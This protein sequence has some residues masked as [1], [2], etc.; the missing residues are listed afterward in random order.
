VKFGTAVA[1]AEFR[2]PDTSVLDGLAL[3][4]DPR[5][6]Y[7]ASYLPTLVVDDEVEV[8]G[9][10][11]RVRSIKAIGDGSEIETTLAKV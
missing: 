7:P 3:S 2:L 6:R 10:R 9:A 11:W 8:A 4:H 1:M 5:L